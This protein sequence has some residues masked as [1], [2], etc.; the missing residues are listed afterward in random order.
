VFHGTAYPTRGSA[1]LQVRVC[2]IGEDH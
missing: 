1:S 2:D